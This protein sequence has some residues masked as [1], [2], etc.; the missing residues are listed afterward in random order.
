ML[1]LAHLLAA[2]TMGPLTVRR[3]RFDY[4]AAV[5]DSWKAQMLLNLVRLRYGDTGVFLDVGQIVAGYT[6]ESV[7]S[8]GAIWNLFGA[9]TPHPNI[10]NNSV[11]A[12]VAGRFTDRPTITYTPLMGERFARSMMGPIPPAAVLSLVQAGNPV[13]LAFRLM[14]SVVN[15]ISNRFGGDLRTRGAD[16]EF[17]ALLARM[18]RVQL[19]GGIGMRVQRVNREEAVLM[20]FRK[21]VAP[22]IEADSLE[23]RRLLGLD[24]AATEFRIVYGSVPAD[25]REVALLTRSALEVLIDLSSFITVPETHVAEKRVAPTADPDVGPDG[26]LRPLLRVSSGTEPPADT[27]VAVPYRGHWFWIDD[28]DMASKRMFSFIMFVFTLVEPGSK[29]PT[30]VLTIPT[31]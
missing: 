20:T 14:V 8:A 31:G 12:S 16:P 17:H 19:S 13:D 27:F 29:E 22:E 9:S 25:D 11:S 2:C 7:A 6:V 23:I 10:P 28:R 18:R 26:P 15:G 3:D 24:P 21:K 30:P 5:A 1:V 4:S